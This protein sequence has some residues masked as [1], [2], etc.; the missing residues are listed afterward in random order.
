MLPDCLFYSV[1]TFLNKSLFFVELLFT[2]I[3]HFIQGLF[4]LSEPFKAKFIE[5]INRYA[6]NQHIFVYNADRPCSKSFPFKWHVRIYSLGYSSRSS[7]R[8]GV[9]ALTFI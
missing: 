5:D 1:I 9:H 6:K 2:I 3:V 4:R 7:T 8:S